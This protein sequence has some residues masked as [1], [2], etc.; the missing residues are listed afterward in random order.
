MSMC[1]YL[2]GIL[3]LLVAY[4]GFTQKSPSNRKAEAIAPAVAEGYFGKVKVSNLEGLNTK[5]LEMCPVPFQDGLVFTSTRR[6]EGGDLKGTAIKKR[7]TDLYFSQITEE[8]SFVTPVP[9]AGSI[10]GRLHDGMA[11]FTNDGKTMYF[12]RNNKNGRAEDGV[13]DLKICSAEWINGEW[14]N[15]KDLSFNSKKFSNCHPSLSPDN[16]KLYFSSNRPGGFGGMD[17]YISEWVDGAWQEP[18]NLGKGMNSGGN[19]I[20][21][22]AAEGGNLFFSSDGHGGYGG[23]DIFLALGPEGGDWGEVENVG[24][25]LNSRSD[26]FGF[27][28]NK[29]GTFGYLT[30]SRSGGEGR[31]DV[32]KW[33]VQKEQAVAAIQQ[34]VTQDIDDW[35][36]SLELED[37]AYENPLTPQELEDMNMLSG[38]L[39]LMDNHINA[40]KTERQAVQDGDS[41]LMLD[42]KILDALIDK[43]EVAM[44][45]HTKTL[46][47]LSKKQNAARKTDDRLMERSEKL[48]D[49]IAKHERA[50][51][52]HAKTLKDLM[53]EQK[54]V[55]AQDDRLLKESNVL[56]ERIKTHE[57]LMAD[58]TY[59][60]ASLLMGHQINKSSQPATTYQ[61]PDE[62]EDFFS[63]ESHMKQWEKER[64]KGD[65]IAV[66]YDEPMTLSELMASC[67]PAPAP[68]PVNITIPVHVTTPVPVAYSTTEARPVITYNAVP[69][70]PVVGQIVRLDKIYYDF[71]KAVLKPESKQEL[72]KVVNLMIQN[73]EMEITVM[74]HTDSRGASSYNFNLSQQRAEAVLNYLVSR[75]IP[76]ARLKARGY[77]E[78]QLI[79]QC[80][81]NIVCSDEEHALNRRTEFLIDQVGHQDEIS[82]NPLTGDVFTNSSLSWNKE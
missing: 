81:D 76:R 4:P 5:E 14:T 22:F 40:L 65:D 43:H 3:A 30:S 57:I 77:G 75:N 6:N 31:D 58:H 45:L 26:D 49:L 78:N 32:Y 20:F 54:A 13:V 68:A 38:K 37:I 63:L 19:E 53:E 18:V 28:S 50:M 29:L 9:L 51:A 60:L 47:A 66:V 27:Y 2:I 36:E 52:S 17:I 33:E 25:P 1:R 15:V 44:Q 79:N 16:T 62:A 64:M 39:E 69:E 72:E 67:A 12:T 46:A 56:D 8:G 24:E 7:Y 55:M 21:P 73:T 74:S 61:S 59:T 23:L 82:I 10:N 42:S 71:D 80:A 34:L 70:T 48:N 11:A 35:E 41:R